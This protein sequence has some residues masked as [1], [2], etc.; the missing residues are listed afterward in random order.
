MTRQARLHGAVA[1]TFAAACSAT[2]LAGC[3]FLI[4]FDAAPSS[5]DAGFDSTTPT[6]PPDVRIEPADGSVPPANDGGMVPDAVTNP[7]ADPNACKGKTDGKYCANNQL[8]WPGNT[9]DLITCNE[10]AVSVRR[11]V[12]GSKCIRMANGFPDQCD[13]CSKTPM[14]GGTYCGRDFGWEPRNA[15]RLVKCQNQAVVNI[16]A[17]ACAAGCLSKGALSACK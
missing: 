12:T 7:I 8:A 6:G 17:T 2:T 16:A 14:D 15:E 4:D 13:E 11:C 3:T 10:Q 9:D 5:G 1:F